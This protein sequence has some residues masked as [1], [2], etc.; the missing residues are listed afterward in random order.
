M[1]FLY[2]KKKQEH[3]CTYG[4]IFTKLLNQPAQW[5]NNRVLLWAPFQDKK[6]T[7]KNKSASRVSYVSYESEC[8]QNKC[9]DPKIQRVQVSEDLPNPAD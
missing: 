6:A 8:G 3:P 5:G 1:S 7:E 9:L 4:D 2:N